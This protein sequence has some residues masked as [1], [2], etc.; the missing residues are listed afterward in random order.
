MKKNA[1][2][3][4]IPLLI[5]SCGQNS[6]KVENQSTNPSFDQFTASVTAEVGQEAV[7]NESGLYSGSDFNNLN[8]SCLF[9]NL[10]TT[11]TVVKVDIDDIFV[12][13]VKEFNSK[14]ENSDESCPESL[15]VEK[16]LIK[17]THAG[18]I[19]Q[20]KELAN[21]ERSECKRDCK[22]S[23]SLEGD[24]IAYNYSGVYEFENREVQLSGKIIPNLESPWLTQF[25]NLNQNITPLGGN[26]TITMRQDFKLSQ[27]HN[28]DLINIDY[29][30]YELEIYDS[31]AVDVTE[32]TM[33][34][35]AGKS[36]IQ[37]ND[38]REVISITDDLENKSMTIEKERSL[39]TGQKCITK[40]IAT[41]TT[42][43]ENSD[44][45]R[46]LRIGE[47]ILTI[48]LNNQR[49][50]ID[51]EKTDTENHALCKD[52]FDKDRDP[53]TIHKFI[54]IDENSNLIIDITRTQTG[55]IFNQQ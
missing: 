28:T 52:A 30:N 20:L 24:T 5:T 3:L 55:R 13:E 46:R 49:T 35:L 50:I 45:A 8:I 15:S 41:I 27:N 19:R 51:T 7:S 53:T 31:L 48:R 47:D 17:R 40:T 18:E 26:D 10:K 38:H 32:D 11:R 1:L 14:K 44:Q 25:I 16:K 54:K 6:N 21:G 12:Y 42:I 23:P 34:K 2:A 9:D 36:Y 37:G 39:I 22:S 43:E 33:Q 4:I 29:D